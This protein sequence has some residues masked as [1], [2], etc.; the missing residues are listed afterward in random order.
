MFGSFVEHPECPELPVD[1]VNFYLTA[2]SH[3]YS[4]RPA[5]QEVEVREGRCSLDVEPARRI[6]SKLLGS[7]C[8]EPIVGRICNEVEGSA[9]E[10]TV[11]VDRVLGLLVGAWVNE[12]KKE[13]SALAKRFNAADEN[14][15]GVL[16]YEEFSELCKSASAEMSGRKVEE[17]W[18]EALSL[19]HSGSRITPDAFQEVGLK[20]GLGAGPPLQLPHAET[21]GTVLAP[22]QAVE[23][24]RDSWSWVKPSIGETLASLRQG[25]A[26]TL[27]AELDDLSVQVSELHAMLTTPSDVGRVASSCWTL[28]GRVAMTFMGLVQRQELSRHETAVKEQGV[29]AFA[30]I[31]R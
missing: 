7:V 5:L 12:R 21:P 14:N 28:Y 9:A 16:S 18:C 17:L 4:E 8:P 29:S 25:S 10:G 30:T 2:L 19:S 26:G 13:G 27:T 31:W 15:D 6:T 1:G 22:F 24:L 23:M 11:D 3:F 20:H